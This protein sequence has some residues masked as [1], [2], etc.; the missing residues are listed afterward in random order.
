LLIATPRL[1]GRRI[2]RA[3]YFH[4][5]E[6]FQS[7]QEK[8]YFHLKP[9][10]KRKFIPVSS[11]REVPI[12]SPRTAKLLSCLHAEAPIEQFLERFPSFYRK[13]KPDA[14][15][16]YGRIATPGI[17]NTFGILTQVK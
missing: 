10:K 1:N 6:Q 17:L 13:G 2:A 16:F 7:T 15:R 5:I 9:K 12:L 8:I 11:H 14:P 3:T 4:L